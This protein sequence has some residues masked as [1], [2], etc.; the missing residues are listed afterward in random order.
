MNYSLKCLV[1][2]E[3]DR[4]QLLTSQLTKFYETL[5]NLQSQELSSCLEVTS[6][7]FRREATV[8]SPSLGPSQGFE[9]HVI[10]LLKEKIQRELIE[11]VPKIRDQNLRINE[12]QYFVCTE[13]EHKMRKFENLLKGKQKAIESLIKVIIQIREQ[14]VLDI[15]LLKFIKEDHQRLTEINE[16]LLD[17]L[18]QRMS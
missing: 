17:Q 7:E 6:L 13:F 12:L 10:C 2:E 9:C 3:L 16:E 18:A 4:I 5:S 14:E 1:K 11:L 15:Q 8:E